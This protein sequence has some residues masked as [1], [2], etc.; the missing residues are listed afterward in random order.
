MVNDDG[1]DYDRSLPI[2]TS[3]SVVSLHTGRKVE[4]KEKKRMKERKK[5][6]NEEKKQQL[7]EVY[8]IELSEGV[9]RRR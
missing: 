3:I 4:K 7:S 8:E 5:E 1:D 6:R 2:K 9:K